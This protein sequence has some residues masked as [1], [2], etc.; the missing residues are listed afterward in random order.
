MPDH[1]NL[2]PGYAGDFV[3]ASRQP[4]NS[5]SFRPRAIHSKNRITHS[6]LFCLFSFVFILIQYIFAL[7]LTASV[8][9]KRILIIIN[10]C[11]SVSCNAISLKPD[12]QF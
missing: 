1:P 2:S 10:E 4:R 12:H 3:M 5:K 7:S 8:K 6:Y 9:K 11:P